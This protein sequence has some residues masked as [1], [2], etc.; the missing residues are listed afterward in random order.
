MSDRRKVG[1]G[2]K[3]GEERQWKGNEGKGEEKKG[4]EERREENRIGYVSKLVDH[5]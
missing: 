5:S 3:E 2:R 1:Q 4:E